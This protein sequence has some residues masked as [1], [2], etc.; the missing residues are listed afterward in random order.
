MGTS[1]VGKITLREEER[2]A[3][4]ELIAIA[5]AKCPETFIFFLEMQIDAENALGNYITVH[6]KLDNCWDNRICDA[7][8]NKISQPYI[9]SDNFNSFRNILR[10]LIRLKY[11]PAIEHSKSLMQQ[12]WSEEENRK[13]IIEASI[14]LMENTENSCWDLIWPKITCNTEYGKELLLEFARVGSTTQVGF[15]AK[16][17]SENAVAELYIW[18]VHQFPHS[19]DPQHDGAHSMG[20]REQIAFFRDDLL[21][22]LENA[23]QLILAELLKK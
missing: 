23:E 12:Q 11:Q 9:N 18:L 3:G 19:E 17:F 10:T 6:E 21:R 4:K 5:Y 13:K 8:L 14:A 15:L 2:R 1:L 22:F 16:I 7:V 20:P